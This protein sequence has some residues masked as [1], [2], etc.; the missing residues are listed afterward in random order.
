[1]DKRLTAP[2]F[3]SVKN[4]LMEL[5]EIEISPQG[6]IFEDKADIDSLGIASAVTFTGK[7]RGR[8]LID[9]E[10]AL[11][12][13][14]AKNALMEEFDTVRDRMVM[15]AVSES[16]NMAS[17]NAITILNNLGKLGLRLAPP[18]VFTG[19]KVIIAIPKIPSV[20]GFFTS[21]AHKLRINVAFER[22]KS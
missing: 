6:D 1:M 19:N 15:A 16:A 7:L 13:E 14:L 2:F 4:V 20:S 21:G 11:A 8:L 18:I 5:A 3:E 9:M 10:P 22:G 12:I 17:G